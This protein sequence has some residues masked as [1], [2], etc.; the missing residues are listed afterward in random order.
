MFIPYFGTLAATMYIQFICWGRFFE[1][2]VRTAFAPIGM[3]DVVTE[4]FKFSNLKY[5]KKL[6]AV[7][8][9]GAV[10]LTIMRVVGMA[11]GALMETATPGGYTY[12]IIL[13]TEIGL[14]K[15]A[16]QISNDILGI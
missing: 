13:F 5:F 16:N 7:I 6:I 4:G 3:V 12:L 2:G 14:I 8:F 15:K 9:Q 11:T 10:I 1:I